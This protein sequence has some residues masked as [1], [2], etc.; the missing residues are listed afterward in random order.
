ML[1]HYVITCISFVSSEKLRSWLGP[2][3]Y[4]EGTVPDGRNGVGF[5]AA[6]SQLFVFGGFVQNG[7]IAESRY[8]IFACRFPTDRLQL[9][10]FGTMISFQEAL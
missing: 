1:F 5:T 2:Y 8:A 6:G 10:F 7:M 3:Q 4:N 9:I